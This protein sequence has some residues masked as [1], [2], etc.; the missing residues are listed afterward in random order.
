MTVPAASVSGGLFGLFDGTDMR[1][2]VDIARRYIGESECQHDLM[3]A[4]AKRERIREEHHER[5]RERE[6]KTQFLRK[7]SNVVMRLPSHTTRAPS[8][9]LKPCCQR[10]PRDRRAAGFGN[11]PY[12]N[13][14]SIRGHPA[15][16]DEG[17]QE[18][19]SSVAAHSPN[20]TPAAQSSSNL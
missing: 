20:W 6:S 8:W 14:E 17:T 13:S 19:E 2:L 16:L 11:L 1:K 12:D 18:L 15:L 4:T 3:L 7:V 5:E 10:P 9:V